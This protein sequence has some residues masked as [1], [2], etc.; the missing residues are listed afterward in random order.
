[1]EKTSEFGSHIAAASLILLR[2]CPDE[3]INFRKEMLSAIIAMM[4]SNMRTF[5]T[6]SMLEQLLDEK[7]LLGCGPAAQHRSG[8][9][10]V[11]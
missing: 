10:F 1:M 7:L 6:M 4:A 5:Y 3:Y 9:D 11:R 8:L 2:S